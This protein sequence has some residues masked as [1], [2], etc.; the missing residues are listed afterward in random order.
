LEWLLERFVIDETDVV[1][2]PFTGSGTTLLTTEQMTDATVY[3]GEVNPE[4]CSKVISAWQSL[5]GKD[6]EVM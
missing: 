5:T 2:D 6:A 1:I 3:T 4:Y